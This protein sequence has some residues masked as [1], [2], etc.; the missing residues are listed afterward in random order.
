M[1]DMRLVWTIKINGLQWSSSF[2]QIIALISI[3]ILSPIRYSMSSIINNF[4]ISLLS[5]MFIVTLMQIKR[6]LIRLSL[7]LT[8][9]IIIKEWRLCFRFY[10]LI[11]IKIF[12]W[13]LILVRTV[14]HYLSSH[15]S[16]FWLLLR[17]A[18]FIKS[19][20]IIFILLQHMIVVTLLFHLLKNAL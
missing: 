17:W 7:F 4:I 18:F 10:F 1:S 15:N 8:R 2:V 13:N 12:N 20:I 6:F 9:F 16:S 11:F 3:L 14:F 19:Q 5:F